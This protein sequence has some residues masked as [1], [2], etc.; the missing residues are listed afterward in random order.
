LTLLTLLIAPPI[1]GTSLAFRKLARMISRRSQRAL[2]R[3]NSSIQEAITGITVAKN[4]RQEGA[5]YGEFK[6]INEQRYQ[7]NLREGML[8]SGI[9]PI[10]FS[11]TNLGAVVVVY[12][13]GNAVLDHSISAGS[14]YLFIQ[15]IWYYWNPMINIASFWSQFQV[16]LAASERVF[17]LTDAEPRVRQ[18][19][20]APVQRVRGRIEFKHLSFRYTEQEQVLQDFNLTI[21][22]GETVAIV[23]HTGAGKTTLGRLVARFY[24]YQGGELLIDGRD[25]RGFDL[26][27]YRRHLGVVGQV[28]F[29][30]AG[31]V[32]DNIRYARPHASDEDV[33]AAALRIGWGDWLDALPDGLESGCGELGKGLSLGQR[34]LVAL[35][36]LLLQDPSIIILDEATA[37][38]DP[39]TEAQ[40]QEGLDLVLRDRTALVI[41]HRLSTI[42]EADRI[43]VLDHGRITEE[44]THESL[45]RRGGH[46]AMLYNTYFRHQS[47]DYQPGGGFVP[48]AFTFEAAVDSGTSKERQA[49]DEHVARVVRKLATR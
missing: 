34:Q 11:L 45:L 6:A 18:F 44:G 22:A 35:A 1:M 42:R 39:L 17:A 8:Y 37:S 23:G 7:V 21:R 9:Y 48:V 20:A 24:E 38:V 3:V 32:A 41:A 14:W 46:Y 26:Q 29:L 4:F 2:A 36:R 10:L 33:R 40:I 31:T 28:P 15:A 25:I 13:G 5:M 19:A 43:I 47:P 49:K 12:F 27:S 16:G 30:F